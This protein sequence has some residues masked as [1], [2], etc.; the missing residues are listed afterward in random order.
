MQTATT[1]TTALD[2]W[3]VAYDAALDAIPATRARGDFGNTAVYGAVAAALSAAGYSPADARD[4]DTFGAVA[5]AADT[6]AERRRLRDVLGDVL[7]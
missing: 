6:L 3:D 2:A 4:A 7:G 5:A 1:A